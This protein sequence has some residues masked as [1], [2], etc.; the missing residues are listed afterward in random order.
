[1]VE[2]IVVEGYNALLE[3]LNEKQGSVLF[4]LFSGSLDENGVSWCPDCVAADPVIKRNLDK[5]PADS[6]FIHCHVGP[7]EYWKDQNNEFRKDPKLFIK[8]VP[9][10]L[11]FGSTGNKGMGSERVKRWSKTRSVFRNG[12]FKNKV[13]IVTGGGTGI[14]KGITK[15]LL[16]LGCNVMIASR[17]NNKLDT[18]AKEIKEWLRNTGHHATLETL[19][20]NIRKE[21][22]IQNLMS[23][24][25]EKFGQIDFVVNNGGG[26]FISRAEDIR[27][28]GWNAVV[29]TNLTGTFLMCREAYKHW[30]KDN[31]G[32][33]VNIIVDMWKGFPIMSHSGA[34]RAGVDNLTKSLALE[35]VH[36][37]VRINS[38]AP[39]SSIYSDTAAANYGDVN[40]F[41]ENKK[42]VPYHRLG[43]VEEISSLVCFLLSPGATFITGE[44]VRAD[45]GQSHYACP[46]LK[47]P[48]HSKIP[49]YSWQNGAVDP[50]D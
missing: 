17:N 25:L 14:G 50:E 11:R 31:G 28:K 22:E 24:T 12:L 40:I 33:I 45:A 2:E 16:F 9:T 7:R 34:A 42:T 32:A 35:W 18:G 26:Q 39:G 47:I 44:T 3:C 20:C 43:T 19:P 49:P 48:P 13:A 4:V 46:T 1:M 8:C 37:G 5:A 41:E 38:V 21:E 6:V 15:E 29:E 27:L 36:S 23:H 30:M 10:L